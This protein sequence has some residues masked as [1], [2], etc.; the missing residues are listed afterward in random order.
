MCCFDEL[1]HFVA[2]LG[3]WK[4]V[5]DFSRFVITFKRIFED[6]ILKVI[7]SVQWEQKNGEH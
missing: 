3:I 7:V 1:M 4:A 5:V 6:I 2:V